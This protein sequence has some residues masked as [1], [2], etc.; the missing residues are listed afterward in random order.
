MT[1]EDVSQLL[2][3]S[4]QKGKRDNDTLDFNDNNEIDNLSEISNS[5]SLD[6]IKIYI[7]QELIEEQYISKDKKERM[8]IL[9]A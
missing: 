8:I 1:E 9:T 7:A 2:D 3:K 5:E 4:G 6:D